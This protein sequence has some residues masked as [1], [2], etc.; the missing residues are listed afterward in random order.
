MAGLLENSAP[1]CSRARSK[2]LVH[3]DI[4]FT[5]TLANMIIALENLA[6]LG[7]PDHPQSDGGT[8][9][10]GTTDEKT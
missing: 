8:K 7:E 1:C 9:V 10:Q 5:L 3:P 6:L 4:Q 2:L